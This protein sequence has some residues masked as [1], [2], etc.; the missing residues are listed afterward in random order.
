[1]KKNGFTLLEVIIVLALIT[2]ILGLSTVYFAGLLPAA[3]LDA[4][5]REITALIRHT[6]SL[7]R[8]NGKTQT[9]M[10]DLDEGS[11]GIGEGIIKRI[12]P[13]VLIKIDDPVTGEIRHGKYPFVFHPAGGPEGGAIILSG[14]K[15]RI[16]I[17]LD[18]LTGVV[19]IKKRV[20][21]ND[22]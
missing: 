21:G 3:K 8:M 6:R 14:G 4:T 17:D 19:M 18:P 15:K 13:H 20:I 1:M 11:F 12:P 10:F 9:V 5:G 7:A 22:R 2:L 16:R